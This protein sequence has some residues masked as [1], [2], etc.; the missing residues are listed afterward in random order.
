VG[1][2]RCSQTRLG[3]GLLSTP[4][5][6]RQLQGPPEAAAAA[7][8]RGI[9]QCSGRPPASITSPS[10]TPLLPGPSRCTLV[11]NHAT[12][13]AACT[14]QSITAHGSQ[15]QQQAVHPCTPP[16]AACLCD[17]S[18]P[19]QAAGAVGMA[20]DA[21]LTR[22]GRHDKSN[23]AAS[24]SGNKSNHSSCSGWQRQQHQLHCWLCLLCLMA[25]QR[26]RSAAYACMHVY[27]CLDS[28]VKRIIIIICLRLPG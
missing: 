23:H 7:G 5:R 16:P 1:P 18:S 15:S 11:H 3:H 28:D 24:G 20:T 2:P 14:G 27:K 19:T 25:G 13:P 9:G 6:Q 10:A 22:T 8:G 26:G 17:A 4:G 21:A 12:S